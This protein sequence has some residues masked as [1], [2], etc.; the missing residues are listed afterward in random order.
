MEQDAFPP[1]SGDIAL[2][3]DPPPAE[4][5]SPPDALSLDGSWRTAL[6][7]DG[8]Q[9]QGLML[10][11]QTGGHLV[12]NQGIFPALAGMPGQIELSAAVTGSD[13]T[14]AWSGFGGESGAFEWTVSP[15]GC[16]FAG[17]WRSGAGDWTGDWTGARA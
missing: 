15:D 2:S 17:R 1:A 14:G 8:R 10:V 5:P 9:G 13:V 7:E 6:T 11:R 12:A 16:S 3:G 4:H